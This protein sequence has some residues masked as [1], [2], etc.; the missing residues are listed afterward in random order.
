MHNDD[1]ILSASRLVRLMLGRLFNDREYMEKTKRYMEDRSFRE[2]VDAI[3][4]G[5]GLSHPLLYDNNFMC[6]APDAKDSP[7]GLR[8]DFFAGVKKE[9][10]PKLLILLFA[11]V[12]CFWPDR[13]L[14]GDHKESEWID[15][16]D[17]TKFMFEKVSGINASANGSQPAIW[18]NI[19]NM[20]DLIEVKRAS[21]GSLTGLT[22][23]CLSRMEMVGFAR[24]VKGDDG[25]RYNA[26]PQ[27]CAHLQG[28]GWKDF[29][30]RLIFSQNR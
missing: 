20:K 17:V 23:L 9:D 30:T 29:E 25:T 8:S 16:N 28:Q 11:V 6:L 21:S 12:N 10:K 22:K 15:E 3:C 26:T 24:S 7:F 27:L 18:R 14:L 2:I 13:A 1:D 5:L 4:E 19:Y